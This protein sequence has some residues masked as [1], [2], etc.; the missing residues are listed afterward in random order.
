[1]AKSA[2]DKFVRGKDLT[3]VGSEVKS[4]LSL[5]QDNI[6]DLQTIRSG[7]ALGATALQYTPVGEIDPSI[8]PAD[9]ATREE[10]NLC[11]TKAE[12]N[13]LGQELN[14]ASFDQT[15]EP[16][17]ASSFWKDNNGV[18]GYS[19]SSMGLHR[20]M[21]PIGPD[22]PFSFS[23]SFGGA[24]P[25][26]AAF[27]CDSSGNILQTIPRTTS[28]VS[29]EGVT[30]SNTA[31]IYINYLSSYT[32]T[33]SGVVSKIEGIDESV[34]ELQ[35]DTDGMKEELYGTIYNKD[36]LS[37][38]AGRWIDNNGV[39]GTGSS[40]SFVRFSAISVSEGDR[41]EYTTSDWVGPCL[42]LADDSDNIIYK[43]SIQNGV[44]VVPENATRAYFTS[45]WAAFSCKINGLI[46]LVPNNKDDI[47]EL[48]DDVQKL[49]KIGKYVNFGSES[50]EIAEQNSKWTLSNNTIVSATQSGVSRLSRIEIRDGMIVKFPYSS[51]QAARGFIADKD[52]NYLFA[53]PTMIDG[54]PLE[55]SFPPDAKW[56]YANV[57]NG[58]DSIEV[59]E[60]L[61]DTMK[62]YI[63]VARGA[64]GYVDFTKVTF[65]PGNLEGN[66]YSI[67]S[68]AY[69]ITSELLDVYPGATLTVSTANSFRMGI[70]F[71]DN[72]YHGIIKREWYTSGTIAVPD[73]ASFMRVVL[74]TPSGS[75]IVPTIDNAQPSIYQSATAE[76]IRAGVGSGAEV[77]EIPIVAPSPQLP[78][79]GTTDADFNA[80]TLTPAELYDAFDALMGGLPIPSASDTANPKYMTKCSIVGRDASNTF[81]I[82][83]YVLGYRNRYGWKSADALYAY[84]NGNTIVYIDSVSPVVGATIYSDSSRTDSGKTI[85][86]YDSANQQFTASD[87]VVYT[88][89]AADNIP[90]DVI[91]TQSAMNVTPANL[92]AYDKDDNSLGTA[93]AVNVTTLSLNGKNY[94]RCEDFDFDVNSQ[95]TICIWANEHGPQ[96]DPAEPAIILYRMA[97]DL[98][99]GCRNNLFLSYLKKNYKIVLIPCGNPYG[100]QNHM[101]NNAN[102][103]NI[104]RNY[105]TPGW[106]SQSDTDKGS[107]AGSESETQ[108]IMNVCSAIGAQIAIDVHCLGYVGSH[109]VGKTHYEGYIPSQPFLNRVV[110]VMQG[111]SFSC[112]NYGNAAPNSSS[113]GG[114]WINYIGIAGGLIEMNAGAYASSFDG[115]QHTAHC[116][117][118]DYTLL[119]ATLR[120]WIQQ[121][122]PDLSLAG[123]G[124]M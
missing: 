91:Y 9:Y 102:N 6:A 46:Y 81:D 47:A 19:S 71:Y 89:S 79:D 69:A 70:V 73:N 50:V 88:K 123:L 115:K 20:V 122:Y 112:T 114:D 13:Q 53:V 51:G 25:A 11:A 56:L 36:N 49:A 108:Y 95:G 76:Y 75:S 55:V 103:V 120:M 97:K 116:M 118:A 111:F 29:Y 85:S 7:A 3:T 33:F 34:S 26:G 43:T 57:K 92:A 35:E 42:I 105:N 68:N 67:S 37:Y 82:F 64:A 22:I 60:L 21:I 119:L 28:N 96:S 94:V 93:T 63:P 54:N 61:P 101:R 41:V 8:T 113:H 24:A 100:L 106:S 15:I 98:C 80:E 124:I 12:V 14:G 87:S 44:V 65:F 59:R 45:T 18:V 90:A 72:M 107:Y 39:V 52:N 58:V 27:L 117:E 99:G 48:Q 16:G 32:L 10:L 66:G 74:V 5:K 121:V 2:E 84:K 1:M 30:P 38:V 110:S 78:A 77:N 62:K 104:N 83:A 23:A 17:T 4:K 86:S 109:N 31:G 40:S